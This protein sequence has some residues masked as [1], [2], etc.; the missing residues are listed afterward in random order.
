MLVG[1]EVLVE[2][3]IVGV[4]NTLQHQRHYWH[5][6]DTTDISAITRDSTKLDRRR[7]NHLR[8]NKLDEG[9]NMDVDMSNTLLTMDISAI[10][11]NSSVFDTVED[12][13]ADESSEE[14]EEISQEK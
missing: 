8:V 11:F 4:K 9:P 1:E 7:S 2:P 3:L 5:I 12:S 6:T 13:S 14:E 10:S